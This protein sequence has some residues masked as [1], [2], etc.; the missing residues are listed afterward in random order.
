MNLTLPL[1][2]RG[3]SPNHHGHWRTRATATKAHREAAKLA[4]LAAL[5]ADWRPVPVRIHA[6]FFMGPSAGR[7]RVYRPLDVA[8]AI[9]SLKAAVDGLVD[10]GLT[11]SDSHQWVTWG[12]VKLRRRKA[13]HGG[14]CEVVVTLER[15]DVPDLEA[16]ATPLLSPGAGEK[17]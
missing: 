10:A 17:R 6:E 3:C 2:G 4:C 15:L 13:D 7:G 8:N 5:P 16:Q 1:P 12:E 9:G 14:R 11:P